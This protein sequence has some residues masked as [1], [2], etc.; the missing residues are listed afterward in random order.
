M[1]SPEVGLLA[2]LSERSS[3]DKYRRYVKDYTVLKETHTIIEDLGEWFTQHPAGPVVD[4]DNFKTWFKVVRHPV[5]KPSQYDLYYT[6]IDGVAKVTP[7]ASVITRFKELDYAARI[8]HEADK[9]IQGASGL[10][11]IRAV[12]DSLGT[13]GSSSE[14][15]EYF[16]DMDINRLVDTVLK[17]SGIEWR[18]EELNISVGQLHKSDFVLIGKRPEVGGTT[19]LISEFTHMVKQLPLDANAIIFNNEEGGDKLALRLIQAALGITTA[20]ILAD[21]AKAIAD[22]NTFLQGRKITIMHKVDLSMRDIREVLE[23]G[24]YWLIGINVLEK[25]KA[26]NK[27]DD[28]TRRQRLAQDCRIL[29][30]KYGAV[31]AVS[32][33]GDAAEGHKFLNQSQ[34]YGSRTGVQGEIDVMIMIGQSHE[35]GQGEIRGISICKNKKPTTGRMLPTHKHLKFECKI[36]AERQ[37][38]NSL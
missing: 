22:Y 5:W 21:P 8:K 27:E 6:I 20:D 14:L 29:A 1:Q 32:Q 36:D 11:D 4:W 28:V 25:V 7:D 35:P 19:F 23:A 26:H 31:F 9:I 2:V 38:F 30:D 33:A 34:L 24:N 13:D 15:S 3:Y 18:L 12:T 37:R 10:N 16:I 17:G